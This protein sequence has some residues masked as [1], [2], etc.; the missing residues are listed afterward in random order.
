MKRNWIWNLTGVA[1]ILLYAGLAV[2]V[3][4]LT[5]ASRM[6]LTEGLIIVAVLALLSFTGGIAALRSARRTVDRVF[7]T[8]NLLLGGFWCLMIYTLLTFPRQ[9]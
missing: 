2:A 5:F 6:T 3:Q 7:G 4:K 8:M 1:T 9:H